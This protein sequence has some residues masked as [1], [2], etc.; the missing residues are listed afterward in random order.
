MPL[1]FTTAACSP[2]SLLN[3]AIS[4]HSYRKA[5]D[6]NYGD[7]MRNQ[8]DVYACQTAGRRA[9]RVFF[10]GG[11]SERGACGDLVAEALASRRFVTVF[12]ITA[13][14]RRSIPDS[15]KIRRTP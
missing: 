11:A 1:I 4:D 12:P 6:I 9:G 3:L 2:I 5:A 7:A 14:V 10:Y 15:S 8:L 13:R